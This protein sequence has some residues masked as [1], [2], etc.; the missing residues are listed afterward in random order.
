[1]ALLDAGYRHLARP[2]L[3]RL[4]GMAFRKCF[5]TVFTADESAFL[6]YF[7]LD[8]ARLAG[9]VGLLDLAGG[10]LHQR[11]LLAL[12]RGGAVAGMQIVEQ[13]V[14]VGIGQRVGRDRFG[15]PGRLQL[16]KQRGG[17]FL[18]FVGKLGDSRTGHL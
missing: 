17:R 9:G 3:F 13:A 12:R 18:E 4:G 10:F 16:L 2:V 6:A 11:D 8:R 15:H 1:M 14:L 5:D 7:D